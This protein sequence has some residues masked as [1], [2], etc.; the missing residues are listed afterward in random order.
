EIHR[1][2]HHFAEE[3]VAD[4]GHDFVADPL[5]KVGV[6]VVEEAPQNHYCR[7]GETIECN[8]TDLG[9]ACQHFTV[10]HE[11]S[12]IHRRAVKNKAGDLGERKGDRGSSRTK[13]ESEYEAD[14]EPPPIWCYVT[15]K[16]PIRSP[17][18]S[19][20]FQEG[21]F[22]LL[23]FCVAHEPCTTGFDSSASIALITAR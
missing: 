14:N 21:R 19:N 15:V 6:A 23:G 3:L 18:G 17:G 5:H 16:P 7:D 11:C 13:K 12:K 8:C 10:G 9:P 22:H 20:G 2:P 1:V 4:V